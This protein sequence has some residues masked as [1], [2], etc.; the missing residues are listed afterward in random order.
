MSTR[1]S[2]SSSTSLALLWC[3]TAVVLELLVAALDFPTT[4]VMWLAWL[5]P[6]GGASLAIGAGARRSP[7]ARAHRWASWSLLVASAAAWTASWT[8]SFGGG[9]GHMSM[10]LML[11]VSGLV[12]AALGRARRSSPGALAFVGLALV[13]LTVV[14]DA[15][16]VVERGAWRSPFAFFRGIEPVGALMVGAAIVGVMLLFAEAGRER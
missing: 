14:L 5:L 3:R 12:V 11:A 1:I 13:V 9:P 10:A 2:P 16:F 6:W 4:P 7:G 15:G 8:F